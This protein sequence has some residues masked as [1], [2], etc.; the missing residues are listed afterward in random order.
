M[1]T[2]VTGTEQGRHTVLGRLVALRQSPRGDV[3]L[4][5]ASIAVVAAAYYLVG[6]LGLELAYLNGAVAALWSQ[7]SQT[8]TKGTPRTG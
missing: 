6:R 3:A 2:V 1:S 4:Y 7:A 8:L 5:A